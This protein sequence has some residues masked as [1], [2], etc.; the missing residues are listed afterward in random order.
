MKASAVAH[1]IQG[2]VKY[3]GMRDPVLRLPY[4]D[5]VSVCTAPLHTHTTV[6][7]D[8]ELPAD[9]F[10]VNE[11]RLPPSR[12]YE[13]I[14]SIIDRLR[15]LANSSMRCRLVS[16]NS[17]PTNIGLGAS[18]SAFASIAVAGAYALGLQMDQQA[19][20]RVAR[21]GAGSASRAVVGGFARWIAGTSDETSYAYQIAAPS[22]LPLGIVIAVV[23]YVKSTEEAHAEVETSPF[24]AARVAQAQQQA[25]EAE[26]FLRAKNRDALLQLAEYDTLCLHA[27]TMTGRNRLLLW[28]PDTIR[29]IDTV[30]QLRQ[31]GIPAWFSIDT[32][33]SVYINTYP[34]RLELTEMRIRALGL[35]T[36]RCT[37]GGAARPVE[38][39]LF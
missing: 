23:E 9:D 39:H 13:R 17:F 1:P 4:H 29:V 27:V 30:K 38:Y 28:R 37:V 26:K 19:L 34:E 18:A 7:F 32:G 36:Y 3:H 12:E 15:V 10:T 22:D 20:S 35:D 33:A 11:R 24:F 2:L 6:E 8:E 5:S 21:L 31:E 14:L 25:E 16:R